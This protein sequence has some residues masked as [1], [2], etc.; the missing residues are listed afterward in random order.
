MDK[1]TPGPWGVMCDENWR[2]VLVKNHE[3]RFVAEVNNWG[4][5][6]MPNAKLIAAA[7]DLLAACEKALDWAKANKQRAGTLDVDALDAAIQWAKYGRKHENPECR[8]CGNVMD[9][10][11]ALCPGGMDRHVK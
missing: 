4:A 9:G 2:H 5:E 8:K 7:P 10:A 6:A 1:H 3:S 11:T